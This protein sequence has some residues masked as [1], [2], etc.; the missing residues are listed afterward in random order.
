[1][2]DLEDVEREDQERPAVRGDQSAWTAVHPNDL[3]AKAG[4]ANAMVRR[5]PT[6]GGSSPTTPWSPA[7]EPTVADMTS[8]VTDESGSRRRSQLT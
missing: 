8:S 3:D 7:I 5:A 1:M 6:S 2:I 4:V